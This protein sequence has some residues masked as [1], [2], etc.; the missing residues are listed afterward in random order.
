[1]HSYARRENCGGRTSYR[2]AEVL[3]GASLLWVIDTDE[4]VHTRCKTVLTCIEKRLSRRE[5]IFSKSLGIYHRDKVQELSY[6]GFTLRIFISLPMRRI[7]S[8]QRD[9]RR[10]LSHN[11]REA[12][13]R[14]HQFIIASI[15]RPNNLYDWCG[16]PFLWR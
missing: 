5:R 1:M 16:S 10:E 13:S 11:L 8:R 3:N 12:L 14:E 4:C 6:C 2:R 9:T 7:I 15:N